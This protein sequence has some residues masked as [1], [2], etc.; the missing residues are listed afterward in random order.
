LFAREN[1]EITKENNM[2]RDYPKYNVEA[3]EKNFN[4]NYSII[5]NIKVYNIE[6]YKIFLIALSMILLWS[7]QNKN[8]QKDNLTKNLK[9]TT[10]DSIKVFSEIIP[11]DIDLMEYLSNDLKNNTVVLNF[12]TKIKDNL[13]QIN[14]ITIDKVDI[15]IQEFK[16][17]DTGNETLEGKSKNLF[18]AL[19]S[20]G[21][22][23]IDGVKAEMN[24]SSVIEQLQIKS[25]FE[26]NFNEEFRSKFNEEFKRLI[27]KS[28]SGRWHLN[29]EDN[30]SLLSFN[31][32]KKEIE[33]LKSNKLLEEYFS[34]QVFPKFK[35][36]FDSFLRLKRGVGSSELTNKDISV[37]IKL[38]KTGKKVDFGQ[39]VFENK[40][41]TNE[42]AIKYYDLKQ[43]I[44]LDNQDFS[45]DLTYFK[46]ENLDILKKMIFRLNS[47]LDL[48]LNKLMHQNN[49]LFKDVMKSYI[50]TVNH[51][52]FYKLK[53]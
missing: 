18:G 30:G 6:I 25:T 24:Y 36:F 42:F 1:I 7:C 10:K 39:G 14:E 22:L 38:I 4:N 47:K 29:F 11:N 37:L 19:K 28:Y 20:M 9:S 21:S 12:F 53:F 13:D 27:L 31:L 35:D 41:I 50:K 16:L 52:D 48:T 34:K 15:E 40:K 33:I 44:T 17:A 32:N 51:R 2:T 26:R 3:L 43:L 49:I 45:N 8:N 46:K 23:T 5:N